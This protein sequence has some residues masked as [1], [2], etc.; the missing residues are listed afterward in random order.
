MYI[1]GLLLT[2][3]GSV[4]ITSLIHQLIPGISTGTFLYQ[5]ILYQWLVR[6]NAI[7]NISN[8]IRAKN[9][10]TRQN[11]IFVGFC[12]LSCRL[13]DLSSSSIR[14]VLNSVFVLWQICIGFLFQWQAPCSPQAHTLNRNKKVNIIFWCKYW[15]QRNLDFLIVD[16]YKSNLSMEW[17][18]LIN[19][20]LMQ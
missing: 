8:D 1:I 15:P 6:L 18:Y 10:H 17:S 13:C 4:P 16:G 20:F 2:S 12:L 7:G 5:S 19:K 3:P 11:S 9:G 14:N